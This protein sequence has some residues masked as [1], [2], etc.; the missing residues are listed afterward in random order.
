VTASDT[1][2]RALVV[3]DSAFMRKALSMMLER[4]PDITVV[5]TARHGADGVAKACDLRPDVITMDVE[6]PEMDGITAVRQ[7]MRK[8]PCPILMVSSLTAKGADATIDALRAGAVDVISKQDARTSLQITELEDTLIEKVRSLAESEA[9]LFQR[10]PRSARRSRSTHVPPSAP[11]SSQQVPR[12]VAIGVSTG[13]PF[14]LQHVIPKLSAPFPAPI[15]IVQHM[16]PHFTRSLADRLNAQSALHV[17]EAEDGMP[18]EAGRVIVAAGGRHLTFERSGSS[19]VARTPEPSHDSSH[20]PSVDTML[21][22]AHDVFD[23]AVL[24]VIMT[25]MGKDGLRGARRIH[26][27]GGT[28]FAQDEASCVVYGMPRAVEEAG[29]AD[30]VLPLDELPKALGRA[31]GTAALS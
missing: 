18:V 27:A 11:S 25:G 28:V 4:A 21:H 13:G 7:I 20:C 10:G 30:A 8:A 24:A 12:L 16:P 5:D 3:D 2:I 19:V 22:S 9:R 6:M 26:R 23:D 14:A 17:V 29:L 31:A 1:T 15:A